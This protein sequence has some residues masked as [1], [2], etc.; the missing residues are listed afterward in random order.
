MKIRYQGNE[1]E[2]SATTVA[3]F[4]ASRG[5]AANAV[6]EYKGEILDATA[7]AVTPLE[8]GA[9]LNAYRIVSGG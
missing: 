2:T 1:E 9:E 4:L 7:L 5:G 3:A 6:V 8:D